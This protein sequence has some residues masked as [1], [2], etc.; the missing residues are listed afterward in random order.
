M[1]SKVDEFLYQLKNWKKELTLVRSIILECGLVEDFK[2]KHPCYTHNSKNIVLIHGFK[3][4]AA[5]LFY[6]GALLQDSEGILIQQTENVQFGRQIRFK[7]AQEIIDQKEIIKRYIFEAIEVEKLDLKV[8]TKEVSDYDF[9]EELIQKF[10]E[11]NLFKTAFEN[12]TPGRQKGYIL[13]FSSAKQS[14]SRIT[15]IKKNT[16]RIFSGYGLNDCVC[17]LSKRKPNC[18]GSHKL[19]RNINKTSK[20]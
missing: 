3:E 13:H 19:E 8:K 12:L 14:K 6:N 4:Y 7:N 9:P 11:D 5:I 10:N 15:R 1:L 16:E 18:D 17:G 20:D 2:W